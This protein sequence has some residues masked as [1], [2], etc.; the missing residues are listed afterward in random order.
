MT[1]IATTLVFLAAAAAPSIASA[2]VILSVLGGAGNVRLNP[3]TAGESTLNAPSF[4]AQ[5]GIGLPGEFILDASWAYWKATQTSVGVAYAQTYQPI[6]LGLRRPLFLGLGIGA[7]GGLALASITYSD[8]AFSDVNGSKKIV[9]FSPHAE[10]DLRL[11]QSFSLGVE[12]DYAF[13]FDKGSTSRLLTAFAA[14]R[15]RW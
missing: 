15:V 5:L 14:V 4:G 1:L 13:I 8:D 11:T 12:G 3:G 7:R 10:W 9:F 6:G 2:T